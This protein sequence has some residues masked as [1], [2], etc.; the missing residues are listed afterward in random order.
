MGVRNTL[1]NCYETNMSKIKHITLHH[2]P[3][4]RSVRVK[5][6][7]HEMFGED[8][9]VKRV[10]LRQGA[11]FQSDFLAKNPNHAVPVLEVN[12]ENGSEQIILE[13]MAML[14]WLADQDPRFAPS[15]EDLRARANYLEIMALGGSWMDQ[16]LWNIRLHETILPKQARNADFA[17]FNRDKIQNEI[18]PQLLRRLENSIYIC[19]DHF[20]AAD[21]M[22]GHNLNWARA[23]GL[24]INPVFKAYFKRLATRPAF[25]LAFSDAKEFEG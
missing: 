16:M 14:I 13:S 21:C 25:E 6:L 15:P 19:G 24:C 22:I 23:Y 3:L 10:A 17:Q 7:L 8:F 20:S 2:Y 1:C 9:T 18:T 11:Q 12:Y 4:S 5:W